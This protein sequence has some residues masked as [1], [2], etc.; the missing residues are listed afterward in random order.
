MLAYVAQGRKLLGGA[1]IVACLAIVVFCA[2]STP[3]MA[4]V[5][6]AVSM[7]FYPLRLHLKVIRWS[8][9]LLLFLLHFIM[10]APVWHL[11]SRVD[12]VGGSTGWHRF[13]LM[14][15]TIKNFSEW[16]LLGENDPMSWGVINMIDITNQYIL[17]ALLGGLLTLLLFISVIVTAFGFVG[18]GLVFFESDPNRRIVVYAIGASLFV[19][20]WVY[21]SVSY[22][23]QIIMI[24]YLNLALA[25]AMTQ[26]ICEEANS[27]GARD[28]QVRP[29]DRR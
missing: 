29:S 19:H 6:V 16:W 17:E 12:F 5:L 8:F 4:V 20:V 25:G 3:V 13:K 10:N 1:G 28:G 21:F 22:F 27:S 18:R 7:A 11:I 26:M 14:D 23:G 2:S 15:T 24:W 9:F